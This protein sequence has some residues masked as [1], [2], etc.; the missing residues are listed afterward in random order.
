MPFSNSK[1]YL[2]DI[3]ESVEYIEA[4]TA[5]MSCEVFEQDAKTIAAVERKLQVLSEAAIRLGDDAEILCPGLPWHNIRGIGNWLRHAYHRV[6]RTTVWHT[7][8]EGLPPLKAAVVYAL[9]QLGTMEVD[10]RQMVL[11]Q[12]VSSEVRLLEVVDGLTPE[13]WRFHE[14][15]ERWSIAEIVEHLVL[16]EG[17]ILDAIAN[18]LAAPVELGKK[19]QAA[20]KEPLVQGLAD[21][22]DTKFNAREVVRPVGAWSSAAELTAEFR[23][24]RAGTVAFAAET[25]A[26]L[27]DH[28]FPHIA[29]GDLDCYQWLV[30]LAQHTLRHVLQIE[31]IKADSAYPGPRP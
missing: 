1:S 30:V 15:P 20:G 23:K 21:A 13:Q 29:F 10:E 9:R 19:A 17:F 25:D 8:T 24:A 16:F 26:D 7:V 18:A 12:L 22:R 11:E 2:K 14:M 31:E 27:R 4:F 3:L 5:G 6:D 28:F